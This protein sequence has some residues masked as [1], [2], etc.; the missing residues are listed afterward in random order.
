MPY[1]V[2][3]GWGVVQDFQI[4]PKLV[5]FAERNIIYDVAY[6]SSRRTTNTRENFLYASDASYELEKTI[7]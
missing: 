2:F 3:V 7:L 6:V 1:L 5:K 4:V